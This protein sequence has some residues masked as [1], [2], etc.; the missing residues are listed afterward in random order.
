MANSTVAGFTVTGSTV[1]GSTVAGST[2]ALGIWQLGQT[3]MVHRGS[4][5]ITQGGPG[6]LAH[7][8]KRAALPRY[9]GP[10][11]PLGFQVRRPA[12]VCPPLL[13]EASGCRVL[14]LTVALKG[15]V[16]KSFFLCGKGLA[17]A[18]NARSI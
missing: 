7:P 4:G 1:L 16:T 9:R 8:G 10:P 11:L 14:R 6:R 12:P 17:C 13:L 2:V 15:K 3:L 18:A 5:F